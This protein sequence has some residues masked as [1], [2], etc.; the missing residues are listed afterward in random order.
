[1]SPLCVIFKHASPHA[2]NTETIPPHVNFGNPCDKN[3]GYGLCLNGGTCTNVPLNG[4]FG[5]GF[6][7]NCPKCF[8]GVLCQIKDAWNPAK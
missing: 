6:R 8:Q 7:C 3:G 1:M 2:S 5:L 4:G